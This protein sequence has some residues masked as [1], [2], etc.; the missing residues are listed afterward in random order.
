MPK[1]T[2]NLAAS[3]RARLLTYAQAKSVSF[4]VVLN[5]FAAIRSSRG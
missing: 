4:D 2:K 3:I 1:D 5:R